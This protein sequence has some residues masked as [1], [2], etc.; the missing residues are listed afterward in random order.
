MTI[1]EHETTCYSGRL[2]PSLSLV[3]YER[4]QIALRG[5]VVKAVGF[6]RI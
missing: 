5:D 6:R 3:A 2:N 1:G 4:E